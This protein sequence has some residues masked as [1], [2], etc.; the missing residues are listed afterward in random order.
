[1][2]FNKSDLEKLVESHIEKRRNEIGL[3]VQDAAKSLG[4]NADSIGIGH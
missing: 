2:M 3:T 1:M 4:V